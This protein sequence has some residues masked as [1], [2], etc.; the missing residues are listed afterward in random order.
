VLTAA[1][2]L[3][4]CGSASAGS[5]SAQ[6]ASGTATRA[7]VR[8]D[9]AYHP[10]GLTP[11]R[12]GE[13]GASVTMAE[14]TT[15]YPHSPAD[16][17]RNLAMASR[18]LCGRVLQP[19]ASL[20]FN[21]AIGETTVARGYAYGPTFVG[22]RVVP[23]LGGGVCQVATTLYDAARKAG[24]GVLERH[25]HG[26]RVPY[27][28]AGEDATVSSPYLDLRIRNSTGGPIVIA[29][30]GQD[31][32][33]SIAL[34]GTE[35]PPRTA[36]RHE[37]LATRPYPTIRIADPKMPQGEEV[38]VQEGVDGVTT[39]TWYVIERAGQ[40]AREIDLGIDTYKPSPHIVRY[41]TAPA[42][43]TPV[44]PPASATATP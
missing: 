38:T 22:S 32:R 5:R 39:H 11:S 12:L 28:P 15:V 33:V 17:N 6:G 44:P 30:L 16:R 43:Q 13:L 34:Y 35:A 23:G 26:M 8:I 3:S 1:L 42:N 27:V 2:L 24:L 19:G 31:N 20:S 14:V 7:A 21:E 9:P 4:A 10:C 25:Q 36:F 41:G 37:T 29:A 40:P 18:Y